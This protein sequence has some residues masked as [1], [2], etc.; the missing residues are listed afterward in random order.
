MGRDATLAAAGCVPLAVVPTMVEMVEPERGRVGRAT[1]SK[2][3]ARKAPQLGS[4][5]LFSATTPHCHLPP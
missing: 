3:G 5:S 2:P 1:R 4:L